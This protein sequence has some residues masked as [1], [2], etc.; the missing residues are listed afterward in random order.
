[1][2]CKIS[3]TLMCKQHSCCD[4]WANIGAEFFF[5]LVASI[6]RYGEVFCYSLNVENMVVPLWR[7]PEFPYLSVVLF[8]VNVTCGI[9]GIGVWQKRLILQ[10]FSSSIDNCQPKV[11]RLFDFC[12]WRE[13]LILRHNN[14]FEGLLI[15]VLLMLLPFLCR[16]KSICLLV[17]LWG[18]LVLLSVNILT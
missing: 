12:R 8:A 9:S 10:I 17:T 16:L 14:L 2:V 15:L 3:K 4:V 1:M 18:V 5:L 6:W 11:L 7:G 13:T